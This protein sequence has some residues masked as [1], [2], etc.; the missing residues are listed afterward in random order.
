M[1]NADV[2]SCPDDS[3]SLEDPGLVLSSAFEAMTGL[4]Q[5]ALD[6]L[7]RVADR[8]AFVNEIEALP[9]AFAKFVTDIVAAMAAA[10]LPAEPKVVDTA[11]WCD[12]TPMD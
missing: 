12:S 5:S 3:E 2:Q 10:L 8:T 6:L 7:R 9:P 11:N 1:T 4:D